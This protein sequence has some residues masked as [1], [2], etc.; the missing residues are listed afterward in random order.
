MG[1]I[2]R[3]KETAIALLLSELGWLFF[4]V[5]YYLSIKSGDI[6]SGLGNIEDALRYEKHG[7]YSL[8]VMVIFLLSFL[9][10]SF[11]KER[12]VKERKNA[13]YLLLFRVMLFLI[14]ILLPITYF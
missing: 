10:Y 12:N 9:G 4:I 1:M 6:K 11:F 8:L 2:Y 3:Y 7:V 13:A 14:F 5:F